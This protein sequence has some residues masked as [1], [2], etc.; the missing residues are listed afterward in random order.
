MKADSAR[1]M[2]TEFSRDAGVTEPTW[3]EIRFG[4]TE[5]MQTELADLVATG[6]KRATTSLL[7]WYGSGEEPMPAVGGYGVVV[8]GS[9][10]ARCVV[11]TTSV[12]V[13]PF[14]D[15]DAVFAYDEGEGDRTLAWWRAAHRAFF[16]REGEQAGFAFVDE[17]DVVCERFAVVWPLPDGTNTR[18]ED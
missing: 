5:T 16:E 15:V 7:R 13:M 1:T 4:D 17:M 14:A 18:A 9:G 12:D 8:D 11:R 10:S 2:W 3:R 6:P